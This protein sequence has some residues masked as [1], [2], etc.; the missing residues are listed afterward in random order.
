MTVFEGRNWSQ[1]ALISTNES[2]SKT[3]RFS[4]RR[5]VAAIGSAATTRSVA[6]AAASKYTF[7]A[8]WIVFPGRTV[9]RGSDKRLVI[10]VFHPL[11]Y[12]PAHVVQT[13]CVRVQLPYRVR[14]IPGIITVPSDFIQIIRSGISCH[15]GSI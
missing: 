10:V 5:V 1:L 7:G 15:A 9:L 13:K 14:R 4:I 2:K 8:P 11:E 6:P 12:I 3:V